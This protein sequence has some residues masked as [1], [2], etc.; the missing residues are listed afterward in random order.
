MRLDDIGLG[1]IHRTH[2]GTFMDRF[3]RLL[4]ASLPPIVRLL[5]I[6]GTVAMLLVGGGISLHNVPMLHHAMGAW[7]M[8]TAELAI[9][10]SVGLVVFGLE[11]LVHA[12]VQ[13]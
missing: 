6:V 5:G 2:K 3:G 4:V 7:P 10:L 9:G 1:I 13:R 12:I 8:M 11:R